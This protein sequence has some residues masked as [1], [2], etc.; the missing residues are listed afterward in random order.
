MS[1]LWPIKT[2]QSLIDVW[3]ICHMA[4]FLVIAFNVEALGIAGALGIPLALGL[5]LSIGL[6]WEGWETVLEWFDKRRTV[7]KR[8]IKHPERWRNHWIG[9][10]IVDIVGFVLGLYLAQG[11]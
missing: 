6:A 10:P 4:A 7:E 9:D 5:G 3:S 8:Y 1:W 11:Q 2:G